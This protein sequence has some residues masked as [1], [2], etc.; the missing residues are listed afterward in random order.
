MF[1]ALFGEG[2]GVDREGVVKV[3]DGGTVPRLT[4]HGARKDG[5]GVVNGVGYDRFHKL[6][7][8]PGGL[9]RRVVGVAETV[10]NCS[11]LTSF[12]HHGL[13]VSNAIPIPASTQRSG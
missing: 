12:R 7:W 10:G 2:V 1:S 8:E 9:G 5:L 6:L 4:G 13:L 11:I 3:G